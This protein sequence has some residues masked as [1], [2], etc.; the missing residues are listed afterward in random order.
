VD[1][2]RRCIARGLCRYCENPKLIGYNFCHRCQI[3]NILQ[4]RKF[5]NSVLRGDLYV[6]QTPRGIKVGRSIRLARRVAEVSREYFG[7]ARLQILAEYRGM[8]HLEPFVHIILNTFRIPE[9][10]EEFT[11]NLQTFIMA[12]DHVKAYDIFGRLH[13]LPPDPRMAARHEINGVD[14]PSSPAA[15]TSADG[16]ARARSRGARGSA[17]GARARSAASSTALAESE[18]EES[19]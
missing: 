3:K 6:L 17:G 10:R 5:R 2:R 11:C 9:W 13:E 15:S 19:C 4:L 7:G 16:A 18:G 12:Y 1:S 14:D 8:G